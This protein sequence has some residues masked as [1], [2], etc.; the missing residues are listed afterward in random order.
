M[1]RPSRSPVDAKAKRWALCELVS[2]GRY[3]SDTGRA[4][5]VGMLAAAVG[6][7]PRTC[8]KWLRIDFP[9]LYPLFWRSLPEAVAS[10][11]PAPA[12]CVFSLPQGPSDV[13]DMRY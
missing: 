4:M 7:S 13:D 8:R 12:E 10:W 1:T 5:G 6:A 11:S 2:S 9:E 3:L